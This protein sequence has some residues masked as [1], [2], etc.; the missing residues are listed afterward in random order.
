MLIIGITGKTKNGNRSFCSDTVRLLF[1]L[2]LCCILLTGCRQKEA[3]PEVVKNDFEL[4]KEKKELTILTLYSSTSYFLYKGEEM[5]YEYELIKQFA[6]DN[7][8]GIKVVVAENIARLIEML[9]NR[10]GD[11]IVYDLPV[12]NELKKEILYCGRNVI[13]HQVL[14]QPRKQGYQ[15]IRNVTELIGKEIYVEK[16]SKYEDRI[17]NLNNELGGGIGIHLINRDTL[18]TEDLIEMVATGELPYTLADNNIAQINKTYFHNIDI[19]L[20]VSFPQKSS[21]AVRYDSPALA[22]AINQWMQRNNNTPQYKSRQKRYFELSKNPSN[23]KILSLQKGQISV[24][25]PLF[26]KYAAQINWDWRLIASQ[27]YKESRFDTSAVSWAGARGLMQ[28]MPQTARRH[29]LEEN[30]ENPEANIATA[31]KIIQNLNKS[32]AKIEPEEERIKFILAAYNSGI[33]HILDAI[34]L[35]RKYG[36]DPNKWDDNV[37][38]YIILKSNPEYFN[39]SVCRFGYFRGRET[40]TYVKEVLSHYE[41]YK[42]KIPQ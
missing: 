27:A 12:T 33:G 8:L 23:P 42:Q 5:G 30:I 18:V 25:D 17:N 20:T 11:I 10:Q 41:A 40:Y 9:K 16:G 2:F 28:I 22:Q 4:I 7:Q 1:G 15:P 13:T 21:W 35:T 38:E 3:R 24:Y 31:V 37:A 34:A 14:I 6:D 39:D 29:G 19:S 36:K 26:K 32:F